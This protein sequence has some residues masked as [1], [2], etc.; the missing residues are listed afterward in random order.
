MSVKFYKFS[1]KN[2]H[3]SKRANIVGEFITAR[4]P[5]LPDKYMPTETA[6]SVKNYAPGCLSRY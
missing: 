2:A 1:V 4:Y 6:I 3:A 5:Q